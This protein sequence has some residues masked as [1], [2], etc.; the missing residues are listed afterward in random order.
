M[1]STKNVGGSGFT[2]KTLQPGSQT[3]KINSISL[4]TVPFSNTG[5]TLDLYC[6]GPDLGETFEGF[7]I[8]KNDQSKGKHKG[9][10]GRVKS[11]RYVYDDVTVNGKDIK[12]DVQIVKFL[13]NIAETTG[14]MKWMDDMDG[15][16]ETIEDLVKAFN[17]NAP[18][19]DVYFN[20]ILG[21][22]EYE[23]KEG[24]TNFDL[25]IPK[26][27]KLGVP[28]EEIGKENSR[29]INYDENE[30]IIRKIPKVIEEFDG[31]ENEEDDF[32]LED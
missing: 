28:M 31:G 22:R 7:W 29:L 30:H 25:F 11:S 24:Y 2:P 20:V 10:V 8:D 12:R 13:N 15:K 14:C 21:G 4:G 19:K 3:I 23:N 5:Y 1:I 16:F 6:E 9:Q 18:Y 26:F 32:N 27:S 17:D